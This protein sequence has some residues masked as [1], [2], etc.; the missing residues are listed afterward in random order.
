[1][2]LSMPNIFSKADLFQKAAE[3]LPLYCSTRSMIILSQHRMPLK[4]LW[5]VLA[6]C[7]QSIKHPDSTFFAEHYEQIVGDAK[8]GSE[9]QRKRHDEFLKRIQTVMSELKKAIR[10]E[11]SPAPADNVYTALMSQHNNGATLPAETVIVGSPHLQP[12]KQA[13]PSPPHQP[14]KQATP[15][16]PPQPAQ[17]RK[18]DSPPPPASKKPA[19]PLFDE[20]VALGIGTAAVCQGFIDKPN[21]G[22]ADQGVQCL[23]D[24]NLLSKIDAEAMLRLVGLNGIQTA[25]ILKAVFPA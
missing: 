17:K 22:F 7:L 23:A 14:P 19:S 16:P 10:L 13:T 21:V 20:L 4:E 18:A 11:A 9:E 5:D 1:M 25:K 15:S 2:Y 8:L 6:T 12:P 3:A 24:L